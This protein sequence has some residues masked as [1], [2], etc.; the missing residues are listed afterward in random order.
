MMLNNYLRE[1]LV[2]VLPE[3]FDEDQGGVKMG[4]V[5]AL[6]TDLGSFYDFSGRPEN[7]TPLAVYE[8]MFKLRR[9]AFPHCKCEQLIYYIYVPAGESSTK[10]SQVLLQ[11]T[12]AIFEI[13]DRGDESAQEIN[14]WQAAQ[15]GTNTADSGKYKPVDLD[16]TDEEPQFNPVYFHEIKIFQLEEARDIIDFATA[17]TYIGN[18]IIIDYEYH[19][20]ASFNAGEPLFKNGS[21]NVK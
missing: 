18:K 14:A 7:P 6:P 21:F 15:L 3:Y 4:I 2:K 16:D 10:Q 8:R 12:Q 19:D 20:N 5:P 13:L 9:G 11:T 1:A 17:E